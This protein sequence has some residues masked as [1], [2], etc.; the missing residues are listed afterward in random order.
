MAGNSLT[1]LKETGQYDLELMEDLLSGKISSLKNLPSEVSTKANYMYP[2]FWAIKNDLGLCDTYLYMSP[3][4]Q[5]DH[6]ITIEVISSQPELFE[7]SPLSR[8]I[9]FI[10]N[11]I[12]N[13]P[14][15]F[16]YMDPKLKSDPKVIE[17]LCKASSPEVAKLIREASETYKESRETNISP[18]I[19]QIVDNPLLIHEISADLKNDYNFLKELSSN[20]VSIISEA[21]KDISSFGSEGIR[22]IAD[23][24][25]N[26]T[27]SNLKE[28]LDQSSSFNKVCL[29]SS[30][31][32]ESVSQN[33][34]DDPSSIV[35][36]ATAAWLSGDISPELAEQVVNY[37]ILEMER[38]ERQK[39]ENGNTIITENSYKP[40]VDPLL[41]DSCL[42]T[43][44]Q[45]NLTLP[46]EIMEKISH[47]S[48]FHKKLK[49]P[50]LLQERDDME[51][52][53]NSD[54]QA[55]IDNNNSETVSS[56]S[57]D[58]E[59][60]PPI[61]LEDIKSLTANVRS[62]E[63]NEVTM[64]LNKQIKPTNEKPGKEPADE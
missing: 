10:I 5:R 33:G 51:M 60:I 40:L 17:D 34:P 9:N 24:C 53:E 2:L 14:I 22:A 36:L 38:T 6:D 20:S 42:K 50:D 64:N 62:S 18:L 44:N 21:V 61:S 35:K 26:F 41:L 48:D 43:L 37:S 46:P 52:A 28:S 23:S 58:D 27:F 55:E 29:N 16:T 30:D 7:H 32:I 11:N 39:D 25:R 54:N 56:V 59:S 8:D 3:E 57:L 31:I 13:Y 63:I 4:L 45:Q 15:I 47:Y 49:I 1:N 12:N 19:G